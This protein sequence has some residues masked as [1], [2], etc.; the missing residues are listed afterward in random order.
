MTVYVCND[1]QNRRSCNSLCDSQGRSTVSSVSR[2]SQKE[3][4]KAHDRNWVVTPKNSEKEEGASQEREK[5]PPV[6]CDNP[7]KSE[8]RHPVISQINA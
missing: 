2:I 6:T 8:L 5:E 3:G 1:Y 4:L 7:L